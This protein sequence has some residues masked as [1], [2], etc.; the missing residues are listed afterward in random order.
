MHICVETSLL[1]KLKRFNDH[2]S[3]L[4]FSLS[5]AA[6]L[7]MVLILNYNKFTKIVRENPNFGLEFPIF[8]YSNN[9][10][11]CGYFILKI[12]SVIFEFSTSYDYICVNSWRSGTRPIKIPILKVSIVIIFEYTKNVRK[13]QHFS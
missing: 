12:Q 4:I 13:N 11:C 3:A 9:R 6:I 8:K 2:G 10:I 1:E 7:D 5:S